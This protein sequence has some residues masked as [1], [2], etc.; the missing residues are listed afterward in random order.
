MF[1]SKFENGTKT[2]I[3]V[4]VDD[5]ILCCNNRNELQL[6]KQSLS[7]RFKIKDLG[8]IR[9]Y[10]GV[11]FE[12]NH[13]SISM[14]QENFI[15]KVLERFSMH[16]AKTKYLPCDVGMNKFACSESKLL[17]SPKLYRAI[18]GSLVYIMTCTRPDISYIV[19]RLAQYMDKPTK[20]HLAYAKYVMHYLQAT[21]THKQR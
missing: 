9:W 13:N 14:S 15:R 17:E 5:M 1:V 16:D 10:L 4:H 3:L 20:A 8:L 11:E 2:I 12:H 21:I 19:T 6:V 7:M 18:I